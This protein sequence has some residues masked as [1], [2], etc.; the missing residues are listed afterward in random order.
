M[1]CLT[2][3][4]SGQCHVLAKSKP[5]RHI[6]RYRKLGSGGFLLVALPI[7]GLQLSTSECS[8]LDFPMHNCTKIWLNF[9]NSR[10]SNLVRI[11]IASKNVRAKSIL[12]TIRR[13]EESR[14]VVNLPIKH[15]KIK[16]LGESRSTALKRLQGIEKR[17]S[18]DLNLRSQYQQFMRE[19]LELRHMKLVPSDSNINSDSTKGNTIYF[20]LH[21]CVTKTSEQGLKIRVVFDASCQTSTG[22]SLNNC[23]MIGLV[24]QQDLISILLRFCTFLYV[25]TADIIKMYR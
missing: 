8:T 1:S 9:D 16:R 20:L 2:R 22:V 6:R 23:L 4:Y 12:S 21:H 7:R 11:I 24:V 13:N 18:R 10:A 5:H 19:Y 17:F 14:Y 3:N 15:D 25:I